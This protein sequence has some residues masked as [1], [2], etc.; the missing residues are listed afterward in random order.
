[1]YHGTKISELGQ[2]QFVGSIDVR[3][4]ELGLDVLVRRGVRAMC[5]PRDTLRN[6][7]AKRPDV[8]LALE[9]SVGLEVQEILGSTLSKLDG[10]QAFQ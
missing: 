9:R 10:P 7:L 5:W 4:D 2:G 8:D 1:L 3:A 6:F